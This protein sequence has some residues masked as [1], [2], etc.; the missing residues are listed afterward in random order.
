MRKKEA[1]IIFD[2]LTDIEVRIEGFLEGWSSTPNAY[3]EIQDKIV[4]IKKR[5][6]KY[7]K[8]PIRKK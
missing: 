8:K 3:Q 4:G 7:L 5:L 2:L 1:Q 6:I